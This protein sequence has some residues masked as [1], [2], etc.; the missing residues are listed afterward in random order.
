MYLSVCRISCVRVHHFPSVCVCVRVAVPPG[1][2]CR[3]GRGGGTWRRWWPAGC[4]CRCDWRAGRAGSGGRRCSETP[5]GGSTPAHWSSAPEEEN[6]GP[7]IYIHAATL[8]H[9]Q[10][11]TERFNTFK[12]WQTKVPSRINKVASS[13]LKTW[14]PWLVIDW[15]WLCLSWVGTKACKLWVGRQQ[16]ASGT[17]YSS[18]Q[19]LTKNM[20][21]ASSGRDTSWMRMAKW[22]VLVRWMGLT[23]GSSTLSLMWNNVTV[24]SNPKYLTHRDGEES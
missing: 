19:L 11:T 21:L 10:K 14:G 20:V 1:I 22:K 6:M 16:Q 15:S 5:E 24:W 7:F 23:T 13:Y 4:C 3:R 2:Q 17:R 18:K 9:T 12:T 8:G